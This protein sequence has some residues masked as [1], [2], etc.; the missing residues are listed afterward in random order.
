[1]LFE[2]LSSMDDSEIFNLYQEAEELQS[3]GTIGKDASIRD[4]AKQFL[5]RN[6]L[7][8]LEFV[9]ASVYRVLAS[10]YVLVKA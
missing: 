9:A 5:G 3:T 8:A 1:M 7:L 4:L 6:D 10:R 2:L